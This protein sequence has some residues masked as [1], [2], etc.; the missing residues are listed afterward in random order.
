MKNVFLVMLVCAALVL[1]TSCA[2]DVANR[3]YGSQHYPQRPVSEVQLLSHEPSQPYIV[4]ADFQAR[5]KSPKDLRA[6]A[7]KIGADAVIITLL[8][9]DYS[10]SE[11]WAGHD[12][13]S[14]T[15][16]HIVGTAIKY[17][18]EEQ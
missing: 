17:R 1:V 6:D 14:D 18:K 4:I 8:G 13:Y 12:R 3:Y 2:S 11:E 10:T 15:Y 7:A 9:G 16:D 5:G